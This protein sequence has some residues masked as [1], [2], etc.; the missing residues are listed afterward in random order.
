[1]APTAM[2]P[3]P[4]AP[5]P[6][7]PASTIQRVQH[8]VPAAATNP[9]TPSPANK[10]GEPYVT[11]GVVLMSDTGSGMTTEK[12]GLLHRR[13]AQTCG[14]PAGN[15]QL[16]LQADKILDIYLTVPNQATYSR[17]IERIGQMPEMADYRLH[18]HMKQK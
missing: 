2:A 14:L 15:I 12:L 17:L 7:A 10:L 13:I 9:K 11:H 1:M 4:M 8:L 18:I 5:I 6:T 3:I 16:Q